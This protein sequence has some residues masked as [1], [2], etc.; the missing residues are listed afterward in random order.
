ML[1]DFAI[2]AS[3]ITGYFISI[4]LVTTSFYKSR[5]NN[6]LS[7]S[8]FLLASQM[9]IEWYGPENK[10]LSFLFF[11]N[12]DLVIGVILF[13]YFLI[14]IQYQPFKKSWYKWL[15]APFVFSVIAEAIFHLDTIFHLY[16]SGFAEIVVYIKDNVSLGLNLFLIIW[17]RVLIKKVNA[18]SE[19]KKRWL[20]RLNLFLFLFMLSW[21]FARIESHMFDSEYATHIP[22]III[23]ILSWWVLYYGVFRLQIVVQKDEIH[24]HLVSKKTD[25]IP[26]KKKIKEHT[27]SK[28]IIQLYALMEK[29]EL[30]KDPLLS[31]QDIATQLGISEGYLSQIIN[32]EINKNVIQFVNEYRIEETKK[33]LNNPV[34][35]KYS[36]EAIGMEAGFKSKSAFYN[37]FNKSLKMSPGA[38]RRLHKAS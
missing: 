20:L 2:V 3:I 4:S 10:F 23:S 9:L 17:V 11:I 18:I 37:A 12:F 35:N 28:A 14:Q 5:A 33:L 25:N 6:Y 15:Y 7:L 32:Q 21:L 13:T 31:R 8:L 24:Q 36:I 16:D 26:P 34:F 19:N 1:L 30:Y 38:F 27:V 29:E 22:G